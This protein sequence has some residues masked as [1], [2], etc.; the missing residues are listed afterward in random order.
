M[1]GGVL[2]AT[3]FAGIGRGLLEAC[4]LRPNHIVIG[5]VRDKTSKKYEE[6]EKLPT[7]EGSRLLLVSIDSAN[8][9]DPQ[10]SIKDIK[11]DGITHIDIVIA[12]A[13]ITPAYGPLDK[14]SIQD[15]SDALSIN[16]MSPIQ[17][18]HA[19]RPF[20]DKSSRPIWFSMTSAAGSIGNVE[21]HNAHLFLA[22][23][24]SK[25]AMN[26]FTM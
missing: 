22:Y 13:G 2:I 8:M 18:Y 11:A 19:T 26:F 16:A 12:N 17:L 7:A 6:L 3:K 24:I 5:S 25:A 20:L 1:T 21:I 14:V 23:G 15:V 9:D 10:A 4:L